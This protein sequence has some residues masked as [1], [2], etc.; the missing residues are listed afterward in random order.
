ME[1]TSDINKRIAKNTIILYIR[2]LFGMAVSFYTSRVVLNTLGAEDFGLFDVVGGVI[3]FLHIFTW[4]LTSSTQR[5]LTFSLG[6][7][8]EKRLQE[9]FMT[10][11]FIHLALALFILLLGETVG[12]WFV[13]EKLVV[14]DG[15]IFAAEIVYHTAI[16]STIIS[17]MYAP[18]N[19]SIIAHEKMSAYAY[20]YIFGL[21]FKLLV[22][23]L[24]VHSPW[25]KLITYSWL[26]LGVLIIMTI[27]Q[28]AYCNYNF[29]ET[30]WRKIYNSSIS[31]EM[32]GFVGWNLISSLVAVLQ[33]QGLSILLNLFFG[34]LLNAARA[35]AVQV[36]GV[37]LQ[38][39]GNFQTALN[40]QITKTYAQGQLELMHKLIERS[41]R[42]TFLL[43]YVIA[44]PIMLEAPTLLNIWLVNVPDHTVTFLRIMMITVTIDAVANPLMQA[45]AA[46]GDIKRYVLT[47]CIITLQTFPLAYIALKLGAVPE[48]VFIVH[49]CVAI[50]AFIAR[51]LVIRPMIHLPAKWYLTSLLKHSLIVIAIS[52]PLPLLLSIYTPNTT[53]NSLATCAV[54]VLSAGV[55]SLFFGMSISERKTVTNA[56]KAKIKAFSPRK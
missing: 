29:I 20:F 42:Y 2:M 25:D 11:W 48:S 56:I 10:S 18:Y 45:S 22:V 50:V 21:I 49:L 39:S 32:K 17:V 16:I 9:V 30:R 33:T 37:V 51:V 26:N 54:A 5:Y 3:S 12:L 6:Q 15:R 40:P 31:K 44:L 13:R 35:V 47:L 23:F 14:P 19:A 46:T 55:A 36:Q 34:P 38:F 4:A 52:L 43:I 53:L 27:V 28:I 7:G 8:D 1:S 41:S 24:L